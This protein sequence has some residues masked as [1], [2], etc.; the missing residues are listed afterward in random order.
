MNYTVQ[1]EIVAK[2][3]IQ[4]THITNRDLW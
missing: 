3:R 1:F 4:Y 2:R